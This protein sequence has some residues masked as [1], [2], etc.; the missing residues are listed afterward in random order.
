MCHINDGIVLYEI[1]RYKYVSE[2]FLSTDK[3]ES[4]RE[5]QIG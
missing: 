2:M 4:R 3:L 5:D 1:G